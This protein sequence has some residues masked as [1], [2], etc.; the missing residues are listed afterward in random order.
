M[1]KFDRGVF[2]FIGLGIWALAMTQ[3]LK[4]DLVNAEAFETHINSKEPW[5]NNSTRV[6]AKCPNDSNN[7][8]VQH[9]GNKGPQS[10]E[11]PFCLYQ[12]VVSYSDL[13]NH[14]E[15]FSQNYEGPTEPSK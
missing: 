6:L 4:P 15:H 13:I 10:G 11:A 3:M 8:V 5:L 12:L 9:L 7:F 14:R 2:I 1:S